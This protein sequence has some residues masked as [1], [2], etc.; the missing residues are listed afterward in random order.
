MANKTILDFTAKSTLDQT[1]F[2]LIQESGGT[3]KRSSNFW[4]SGNDYNGGVKPAPKPAGTAATKDTMAV[5]EVWV[6]DLTTNA[7]IVAPVAAGLYTAEILTYGSFTQTYTEGFFLASGGG[8]IIRYMSASVAG[9]V[10]W[11]KIS[12]G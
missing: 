7:S 11:M 8:G 5:G 10:K 6:E 4:H 3:T 2:I 1:D 12:I 9:R